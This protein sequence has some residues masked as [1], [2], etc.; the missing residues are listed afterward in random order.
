M[1]LL[2]RRSIRSC[3]PGIICERLE[4]RIVLDAT[5]PQA[6]QDTADQ[7]QDNPLEP[8]TGE[9]TPEAMSGDAGDAQEVP[10]GLSEAL[11]NDLN[12]VLI[13]DALEQIEGLT[14]QGDESTSVLVFDQDSDNLS[15]ISAM[16]DELTDSGQR[17]I[18]GIAILSHG[19]DGFLT[20]GTDTLTLFNVSQY[21]EI[22]Q[23]ISSFLT[24]DAQIQFFGC[25]VSSDFFGRSMIDAIA[26]FTEA[27]VFASTDPTGGAAGDWDLEFASDES[28]SMKEILDMGTISDWNVELAE[29]YPKFDDNWAI[30]MEKV[31]YY[32]FDDGVHGTELWR[33]DGSDTGTWMV[34]DINQ[35]EKGSNPTEMFVLDGDLYFA[36][37]DGN[38]AGD[39]G[40][41]L[42]KSD[43]TEAGTSMV[44]DINP[45][46]ASSDPGDFVEMGGILYFQATDGNTAA[47][48]GVELWKSNGTEAGTSMVADINP[49]KASSD[50]G[51]FIEMG[52]ILYFHATDGN[53]AGDH[54]VELWKSN[55][56][57]AGT[58][59]VADI[60]TGKDSS[61]PQDFVEVGGILYFQATDGNTAADHGVELWKS[62]GTEAGTSMVR[63]INPGKA[64]SNPGDLVEVGGILYFNAT[65][66]NTAADHGVELWKSDGTEVGTTMVADINVGKDSSNPAN[67]TNVDG[68]LYFSA[69]DGTH[70]SELWKSDGSAGGTVMVLDINKGADDSS[71]RFFNNYDGVLIF[72]ADDGEHGYEPWKSDG[73]DQGTTILKDINPLDASFPINFARVNPLFF[74]ADDGSGSG[75]Q[76]WKSDGTTEGTVRVSVVGTSGTFRRRRHLFCT[77]EDRYLIR[78]RSNNLFCTRE[79]RYLFRRRGKQLTCTGG[80]S[81]PFVRRSVTGLQ[82]F[83]QA[84]HYIEYP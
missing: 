52:G 26:R 50:P 51:D 44:A 79:D 69:D 80:E 43:G 46:K 63:D 3:H 76:L 30:A 32:A 25:S 60:N 42:W 35:G 47:D 70:G 24:E 2:T 34:A 45:G 8:V 28:R 81:V 62:D 19:D 11:E 18:G 40:V 75:Y 67:L 10:Q 7:N 53:S 5:V 48:H 13:S 59:R 4:E 72:A 77:R 84:V 78:R 54:G 23:Q 73:T 64:S 82:D 71:P 1:G 16:L 20:I 58:T 33:S 66:G 22:F 41:E 55:G 74:M 49:G 68:E 9:Q 21:K 37:T 57:E 61:N 29:D 83:W 6:N 36:A 38:T 12:V 31:L 14:E 27:D 17:K 56:T 15:S 65:D 39:H